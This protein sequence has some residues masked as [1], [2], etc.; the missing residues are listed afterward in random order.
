MDA[1]CASSWWLEGD[2]GVVTYV[3]TKYCGGKGG[4]GGKLNGYLVWYGMVWCCEL[5][6]KRKGIGTSIVVPGRLFRS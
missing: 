1:E 4:G 5:N 3:C 6:R 2:A